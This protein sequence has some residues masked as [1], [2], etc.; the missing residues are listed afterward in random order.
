MAKDV[1]PQKRPS[2]NKDIPHPGRTWYDGQWRTDEQVA[3]RREQHKAKMQRRRQNPQYVARE[4]AEARDRMRRLARTRVKPVV[5]WRPKPDDLK[6][7]AATDELM[8]LVV[9]QLREDYR[10]QEG[11]RVVDGF[12]LF[13]LDA[14]SFVDGDASSWHEIHGDPNHW[15][16]PGGDTLEA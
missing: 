16:E 14:P 9:Q 2:K 4:N 8:D 1:N 7:A 13:S 3:R 12:A 5:H 11:F 10:R 6:A 15:R